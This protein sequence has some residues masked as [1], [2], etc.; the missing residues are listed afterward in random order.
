MTAR[1]SDPPVRGD[2]V[3]LI[4]RPTVADAALMHGRRGGSRF[5]GEI[6]RPSKHQAG[7]RKARRRPRDPADSSPK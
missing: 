6:Y 4:D 3:D 2:M 7:K 1:K 5:A